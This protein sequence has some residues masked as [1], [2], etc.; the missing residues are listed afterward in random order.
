MA[1]TATTA[2]ALSTAFS[3]MPLERTAALVRSL[4]VQAWMVL[5]DGQLVAQTGEA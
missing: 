3:N 5:P 1:S 2:D 4:G